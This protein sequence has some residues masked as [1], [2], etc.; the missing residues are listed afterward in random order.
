MQKHFLAKGVRFLLF[1]LVDVMPVSLLM[2]AMTAEV[3]KANLRS[4]TAFSITGDTAFFAFAA[5]LRDNCFQD[6]FKFSGW[7]KAAFQS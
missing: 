7:K 3:S 5:Y 6:P 2:V 1:H 4:S